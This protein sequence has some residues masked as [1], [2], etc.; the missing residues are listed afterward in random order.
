M[1]NRK[2]KNIPELQNVEEI[3][4]LIRKLQLALKKDSLKLEIIKYLIR[5]PSST[6]TEI[7]TKLKVKQSI[8][9]KTL[10]ELSEIGLV[11]KR[12]EH[13][14][15]YYSVNKKT[16]KFILNSLKQIKEKAS[17]NIFIR[18]KHINE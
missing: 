15:H 9:S 17:E 3:W 18:S 16:L 14:Y 8:T 11:F 1:V 13:K 6:V 7:Y 10:T 4:S 2:E 5:Y 12:I